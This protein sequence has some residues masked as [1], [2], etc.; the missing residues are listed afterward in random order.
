MRSVYGLWFQRE[1]RGVEA[2]QKRQ[3]MCGC[4]GNANGLREI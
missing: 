2:E 1:I 3:K 4:V